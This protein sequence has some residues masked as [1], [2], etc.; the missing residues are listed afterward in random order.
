MIELAAQRGAEKIYVHA[1]LDGRDCPPRSAQSSLEK[2]HRLCE[3]L[4]VAKI[5]SMIGRFYAMDRDN[6]WERINQAYQ[7]ITE[8]VASYS[9]VDPIAALKDAYVRGED[10]EFVS[11]ISIGNPNKAP[12]TLDD[13]DAMIFMNFRPDRVRQLT[14]AIVDRDFTGFD[15]KVVR[16]PSTFA[17]TTEYEST[18]TCP[19][20]FPTIPI[21]N[22]L[23]EFL[24]DQG[25]HQL[26]IAETEKYAHVTFFMSGGRD[27]MYEGEQRKL[28][29]SLD[30]A[31]Y[32]EQPEMSAPEVTDKLIEAIE[33]NQF[34]TIICNYANCDMVGHTG[35]YQ[36][37][38]LAVEAV[39]GCLKKV[40]A[41]L[42][43]VGGQALITADHGNVEMMFDDTANQPHT[44]H[45][46]L[47]VPLVYVGR[48]G[49]KLDVGG[50]LADIAPTLLAL[51]DMEQPAEMTGRSLLL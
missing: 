16:L 38:M 21:I 24:S 8:G 14:H 33:S 7:L 18:L 36:A 19:I 25:K 9:A 20:A 6:R 49:V 3:S 1:F 44:Q 4:G 13:G 11:A 5:A 23:G 15:R 39:D 12:V 10:D 35:D 22:S 51:L 2:T 32:D 45:T 43:R 34:D 50:S 47:P 29:P 30:V 42:A 17:T 28:L 27:A 31:T 48:P 40:L 41:S 46:T 26:R 37:A